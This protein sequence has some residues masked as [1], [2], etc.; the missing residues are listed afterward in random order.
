MSLQ[1]SASLGVLLIVAASA[2]AFS[3]SSMPRDTQSGP[4][5]T[6]LPIPPTDQP[7]GQIAFRRFTD[8]SLTS[9]HIVVAR[10]DGSQQQDVTAPAS[11]VRDTL[12]A[13]SPDG[14]LL[15]FTR[16][17]PAPAA[18]AEVYVVG[19]QG[20]SA[21]QL[22]HSPPGTACGGSAG[23]LPAAPTTSLSCNGD[24]TWSPDGKIIAYSHRFQQSSVT[25]SE[26]WLVR[27]D[28]SDAHALNAG[29]PPV[30]D[31]GPAWSP[32]GTHLAFERGDGDTSS[33]FLVRSDGREEKQ[34][35]GAGLNFGD[36]PAW[37]PDGTKILFRSNPDDPTQGFQQ[38][39][40]F[41]I[42]TDG[43]GLTRLTR[44]QPNLQYL[45][46]TWSPDG[47]WIVTGLVQRDSHD[48]QAQIYLLS[49][50]AAQGRLLLENTLWQ[51]A[52]RWAPANI[53]APR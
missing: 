38:S 41:T 28:G 24:P 22:T 18:T 45:S 3:S 43:T 39:D 6:M 15:A 13:W 20:G 11:G 2:C 26:V 9:S 21:R 7:G 14:S 10:P 48:A 30:Q 8:S 27:A 51:S 52:P 16:I 46:A 25:R 35:T 34:L 31:S 5:I 1:R 37:A 12:P 23:P 29:G 19:R 44:S 47:R 42:R 49:P 33:I 4:G 32:D 50:T 40:L 17:T 36:H 53:P